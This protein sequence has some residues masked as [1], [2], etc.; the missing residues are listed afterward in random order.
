MYRIPRAAG[1]AYGVYVVETQ[2]SQGGRKR[3]SGENTRP[4]GSGN[5][6]SS[7]SRWSRRRATGLSSV[8]PL[9]TGFCRGKEDPALIAVSRPG[10]T[11]P[12]ED[13]TDSLSNA[14]EWSRIKRKKTITVTSIPGEPCA[15]LRP[16]NEFDFP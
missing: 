7:Q 9:E 12:N 8:L 2:K 15:Q 4:Y 3:R 16:R 6:I 11:F 13:W 1:N 14:I 5:S 10:T